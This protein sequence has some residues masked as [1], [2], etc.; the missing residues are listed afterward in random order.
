MFIMVNSFLHHT[1]IELDLEAVSTWCIKVSTTANVV[2]L[3]FLFVLP[4]QEH[5]HYKINH[6]IFQ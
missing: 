2:K 6:D 5:V 4:S 1:E 3:D